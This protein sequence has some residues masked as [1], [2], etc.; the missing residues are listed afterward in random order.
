MPTRERM[1][2]IVA[3]VLLVALPLVPGAIEAGSAL[4]LVRLPAESLVVIL[5]LSLIPARPA[6]IAVAGVF[7]ALVVVAIALAAI[8]RVY[9][10]TLSTSFDPADPQSLGDGFSVV[11]DAIGAATAVAGLVLLIG[12]GVALGSAL[13]WAAL[14]TDGAIRRHRG[15]GRA[16]L[17]AVTA[18]WI[19]FALIGSQTTAIQPAAAAAS[20]DTIGAA[21]SRASTSIRAQ[22]ALER[23]S[24]VDAY[25]SV[26]PSALLGGLRGKDVVVVFIESYGRAAVEGSSFSPGVDAVLQQG[27]AALSKDGYG[28]RS[29][30][31]T[32]PTF[33]GIS[34]LAHSTLQSGLWITSQAAYDKVTAT[35][36]LT[37]AD[38]FRRAGWKTVSDVPRDTK[39]WDVGR[40]FYHYETLL[41]ARN[42]GYRGP[43]F[44][45]ARIPDQYTFK[46]FADRMLAPGHRPVFADLDLISSHTPWAPV[47]QLVPW[48]QLG[49][50]SVFAGQPQQGPSAQAVWE[51]TETIRDAYGRSIQY[52]LG[53]L[54]S[55]L[56]NVDDPNLV[57]IALGDHQASTIVSGENASHDVPVSIIARDPAVLG[58]IDGWHW[59]DGLQPGSPAPVW[60]MDAFRDRFLS[61][62]SPQ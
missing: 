58:S 40:S 56:Q 61:A 54:F 1:A 30:W 7:G 32:S 31:L 46:A 26:P 51:H 14:R 11:A 22:S 20:A 38:V 13:A 62:F 2:L 39:R 36:R 17:T 15:T 29:A 4:G 8:D 33:G 9:R 35:Q 45:Y 37:L 49:D 43:S 24:A 55:F 18:A 16:A 3:L 42:V 52:S 28:M 6:R 25:A 48:S 60:R 10:T 12:V 41:D 50:G 19:V 23:A 47:P 44:G 27:T 53:A 21:V 5:V 34:W 59:Q 57:V